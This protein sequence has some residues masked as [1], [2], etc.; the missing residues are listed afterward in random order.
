MFS[1]PRALSLDSLALGVS[2]SR[3]A[4]QASPGESHACFGGAISRSRFTLGD[5]AVKVT[6]GVFRSGI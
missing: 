2:R 5:V 4:A 1:R 3:A 6:R